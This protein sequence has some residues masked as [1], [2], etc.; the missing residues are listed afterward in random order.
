[1]R[2]YIVWKRF[3]HND[4]TSISS[5]YRSFDSDVDMSSD[6]IQEYSKLEPNQIDTRIEA[7][8]STTAYGSVDWELSER[9]SA[10]RSVCELGHSTRAASKLRN[11]QPLRNAYVVFGSKKIHD[12]MTYIDCGKNEY[13]DIIKNELNVFNVIFLED[14]SSLFNYNVKP[15]FRSLGP[16]GFGKAA[17]GLK[18][19]MVAMTTDERNALYRSLKNGEAITLLD[20]PLTFSDIEVE[21]IAKDGLVSATGKVGA[22]VLDTKLDDDLLARGFVADFRSAVQNVRKDANMEITDRIALEICCNEKQQTI[23]EKHLDRM[24]R[25]LLAT[26][27]FVKLEDDGK[28]HKFTC[29]NDSDELLVRLYKI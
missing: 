7:L 9:M 25:D 20:I 8:S 26:I 17:M 29:G 10:I 16:K 18:A 6:L 2:E 15:N 14:E 23:I 12:Y 21:Y 3:N 24:K 19:H 27:Q 13:V 1:M 11:R 22:I 4:Q 5:E 28:A